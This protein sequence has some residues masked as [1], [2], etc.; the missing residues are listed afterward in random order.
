MSTLMYFW[1][2][3][4]VL[5]FMEKMMKYFVFL[6]IVSRF[7]NLKLPVESEKFPVL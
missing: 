2:F 6:D 5:H 7:A 4:S 1:L 3:Y